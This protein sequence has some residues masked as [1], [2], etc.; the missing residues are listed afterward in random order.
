MKK[1]HGNSEPTPRIKKILN[2]AFHLQSSMVKSQT[3]LCGSA[4]NTLNVM[5]KKKCQKSK[6]SIRHGISDLHFKFKMQFSKPTVAVVEN[7][8]QTVCTYSKKNHKIYSIEDKLHCLIIS[9]LR[10]TLA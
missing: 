4:N 5:L 7:V 9:C 8:G 2:T 10:V 6:R 3:L 1:F